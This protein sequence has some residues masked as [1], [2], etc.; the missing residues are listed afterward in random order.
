MALLLVSFR[1]EFVFASFN[2]KFW[3]IFVYGFANDQ[4]YSRAKI[5]YGSFNGQF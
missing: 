2:C 1:A 5:V 4:F 3:A